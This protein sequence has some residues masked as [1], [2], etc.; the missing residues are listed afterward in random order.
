MMQS[1]SIS[2]YSI[3]KSAA[4]NYLDLRSMHIPIALTS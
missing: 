1:Q 2:D 3:E 4:Q